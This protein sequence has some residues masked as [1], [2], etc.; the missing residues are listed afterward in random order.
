MNALIIIPPYTD[1]ICSY[2][3]LPMGLLYVASAVR[4]Q[5]NVR[6]LNL[7]E[8]PQADYKRII[9]Y[10]VKAA[11]YVLTGGLSVHYNIIRDI[12]DVVKMTNIDIHVIV[13]GGLVTSQPDL[14]STLINADT[15][16]DGEADKF[17]IFYHNYS[18]IIKMDSVSVDILNVT[19]PAYD[20]FNMELYLGMQRPSDSHYRAVIDNPRE[21]PIIASRGCPYNCTF[22]FHPTGD[23]YR[24]RSLDS[25]FGEIEALVENYNINILAI[26]DECFATNKERL[27]QFCERIKKY[28][29]KW[30]CQLRV[31]SVDLDTMKM[32][33]DSG[34]YIISFGI[35]S[36]SDRILANY[37]KH[38]TV[39]QIND[40]LDWAKR[41]DIVVQ[42]NI[43]L[44]AEEETRETVIES[45]KWWKEHR[46][47]HLSVGPVI[48]YPGTKMY[49]KALADGK[50]D[51]VKFLE[52]GCPAIHLSKVGQA[53]YNELIPKYVMQEITSIFDIGYEQELDFYGRTKLQFKSKCP[54]CGCTQERRNWDM[55]MVGA[56][57]KWCSNCKMRYFL[58][59]S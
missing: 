21:L 10:H 44:G 5:A 2:Y 46:E 28:N 29:L 37:E 25:V 58:K 14:V 32:L 18:K 11:D 53:E 22:C 23:R 45:L 7:N 6:V 39:S 17:D 38:I 42:G 43:I 59:A 31:D 40:A 33:R 9:R 4:R 34:C 54:Y 57:I 8:V 49:E 30:S 51:P 52:A 1:K 27:A 50:I 15:F 24:Q 47:W 35:E 20:L 19:R 13:G 55:D 12:V 26:Y 36:A 41:C 3:N 16:V 56:G 48:P